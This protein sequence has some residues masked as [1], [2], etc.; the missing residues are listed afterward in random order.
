VDFA[1]QISK[2][3]VRAETD[4]L[5]VGLPCATR[6]DRAVEADLPAASIASKPGKDRPTI[7]ITTS[8]VD[9]VK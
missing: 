3:V 6:R 8:L 5:L 4:Q 7:S 2:E 1:R 9:E